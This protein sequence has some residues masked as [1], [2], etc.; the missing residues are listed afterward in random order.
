[1]PIANSP[2]IIDFS[3]AV[4]EDDVSRPAADRVLSGDPVQTV[5]NL[6]ADPTG[7]FFA[8]TWSSTPGRW[9][10]S[11]TESEFCHL[12]EGVIRITAVDGN[13]WTFAAGASFV[14]PAGFSGV[15]EVVEPAR[16]LY[17]IFESKG[18]APLFRADLAKNAP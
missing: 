16:K 8:G 13:A 15:W 3:G 6:F 4:A 17:A 11:Y 14:V 5:R 7:Q 18:E 1:M 2:G 9:R 12:L 10:V